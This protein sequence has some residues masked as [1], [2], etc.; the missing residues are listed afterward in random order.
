MG[1]KILFLSSSLRAGSNSELLAEEAA[2]GAR[3]AG[4]EAEVISLKGKDLR[5]C[6]GCLACQKTGTC[7]LRDDAG[8]IVEKI[9]N[10]QTLVFVTPIYYYEMSGQLKTLLDRCNPLYPKEYAFRDVYLMTTS[11]E[12]GEEVSARAAEGLK[13]WIECFPKSR[14]AGLFDGG[15]VNERNEVKTRGDLLSRAYGFG[16]ELAK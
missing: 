13:G 9:Q 1:K 7:V 10:A 6:I 5:F 4:G 3:D 11:A 12:E 15:G 8:A 2:R 16:K 14:F